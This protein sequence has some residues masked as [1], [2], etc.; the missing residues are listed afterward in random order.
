M[1]KKS[2][3]FW[4]ELTDDVD[5][6]AMLTALGLQPLRVTATVGDEAVSRKGYIDVLILSFD[7]KTYVMHAKVVENTTEHR[8]RS[9]E[10][11]LKMDDSVSD[12]LCAIHEIDGIIF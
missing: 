1:W 9:N 11:V 3:S 6:S 2:D 5:R 12:D 10:L 4:L 8:L 7:R